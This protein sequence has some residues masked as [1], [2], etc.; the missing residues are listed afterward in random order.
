M[1]PW[2]SLFVKN[3]L[4]C[5][6]NYCISSVLSISKQPVAYDYL[7]RCK[8]SG[9]L[10]SLPRVICVGCGGLTD[11]GCR[12]SDQTLH[13]GVGNAQFNAKR[14]GAHRLENPES[15]RRNGF[16]LPVAYTDA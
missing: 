13:L 5:L 11:C 1:V 9:T 8:A 7:H 14:E 10:L 2:V 4:K 15:V 12:H 6:R 16:I 3:F